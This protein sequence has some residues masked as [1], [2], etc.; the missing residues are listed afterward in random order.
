MMD[1]FRVKPNFSKIWIF[2][3]IHPEL[4]IGVGHASQ[5]LE[6]PVLP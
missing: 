2:D 4:E 3:N 1:G 6:N 5:I